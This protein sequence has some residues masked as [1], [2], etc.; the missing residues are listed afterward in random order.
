MRVFRD[1][2]VRRC[3]YPALFFLWSLLM[4]AC[5]TPFSAPAVHASPTA[6]Q[7]PCTAAPQRAGD[8]IRTISSGGLKRSFLLHFPPGYGKYLQPLVIGYHGYSW[9]M[10]QME[11]L[12]RLND[13][14][15]K[16]GFLLALPQG[17]DSPPSWNAG[18]GAY[19]PTGDADDVQFTHDLLASL[20]QNYCVDSHRIYLVG[21][22]LGGGM[23]YRLACTLH[24]QI[25]AIAT[26]SGAYYPFGACHPSHPFPVMEMHGQADTQAPYQGNPTAH[27]A[28][29]QDYLRRWQSLDG[30]TGSPETF[31]Q[32][33]DVT[34]LE[35]THCAAGSR[36]VHYRVGKG[37][38]SWAMSQS[39][40]TS[41]AVWE[42]FAG[43]R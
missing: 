24:D 9:T 4:C 42:F 26:V 22:S 34:G 17:V 6:T 2:P 27:M 16:A 1:V 37:G 32:K 29:V 41:D 31:F 15:D 8:S 43:V 5:G 28:A 38:H 35:W 33:G 12:T 36:V 39:I 13:E 20:K 40:N 14:A 30:C 21:F 11:K 18:N 23:V 19:G 25:T 3:I 10:Q 7:A